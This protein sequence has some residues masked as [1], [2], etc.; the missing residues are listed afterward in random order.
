M[1]YFFN[2]KYLTYNFYQKN[3]ELSGFLSVSAHQ[4]LVFAQNRMITPKNAIQVY[5]FIGLTLCAVECYK[6][7]L[8]TQHAKFRQEMGVQ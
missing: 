3:A 8:G 1:T 5:S 7:S 4:A 6:H 2:I